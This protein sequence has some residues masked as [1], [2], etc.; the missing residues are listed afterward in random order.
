MVCYFGVNED[1][2]TEIEIIADKERKERE[3]RRNA[4]AIQSF[5]HFSDIDDYSKSDFKLVI[6]N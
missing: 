1:K 4:L 5:L 6:L 3:T 2:I